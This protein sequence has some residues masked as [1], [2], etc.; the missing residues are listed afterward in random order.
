MTSRHD[1]DEAVEFIQPGSI[2]RDKAK[3]TLVHRLVVSQLNGDTSRYGLFLV[4][5][6]RPD[7]G[8]LQRTFAGGGQ[9]EHVRLHFRSLCNE[10]AVNP[11]P[12]L[13]TAQG[14]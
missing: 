6:H 3:L 14:A 12:N 7:G 2:L 5:G 11:G 1:P 8:R 13:T 4:T 9:L 10:R